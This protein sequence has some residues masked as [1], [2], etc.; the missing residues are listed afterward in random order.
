[1]L[2][3]KLTAVV[4]SVLFATSVNAAPVETFMTKA[5]PVTRDGIRVGCTIEFDA[6]MIDSVYNLGDAL[7]I[8]GNV[9]FQGYGN[10]GPHPFVGVKL[11]VKKMVEGPSGSELVPFPPSSVFLVGTKNSNNRTSLISSF[12]SQTP[13]G[14]ISSFQFD[15]N[16]SSCLDR[17]HVENTIWLTFNLK[18]GG[19]DIR[20][21]IDLSVGSP[22]NTEPTLAT[23]TNCNLE[24]MDEVAKALEE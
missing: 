20:L 15:Q 19:L 6:G 23:F 1:M 5:Y 17:A 16:F 4:A 13:G 10:D 14:L 11:V 8:S 12:P 7:A 9:S 3:T 18:P 21:P 22:G 2:K 24:L